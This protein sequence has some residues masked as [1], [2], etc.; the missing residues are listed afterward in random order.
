MNE[1]MSTDDYPKE[2]YRDVERKFLQD[3]KEECGEDGL[4]I[5]YLIV[6]NHLLP[7]IRQSAQLDC[8]S[9][10]DYEDRLRE[11]ESIVDDI[12]FALCAGWTERKRG[13]IWFNPTLNKINF[14]PDSWRD[15]SP[16]DKTAL[17]SATA[18]YL[19]CPWMQLNLLE[20]YILNGYIF[21]ETARLAD[22]IKSGEAIGYIN[23]A[24]LFSSGNLEKTIYWGT[25][26]RILKFLARWVLGPSIIVA[27]Y[28][29]GYQEVAKWAA[30]FYGIY[31]SVHI[32]FFPRR[33][34][35]RRTLRN[36][37]K[38]LEDKLHAL[39]N[40]YQS[41]SVEIFNPS[42]LREIIAR[43]ESEEVFFRPAVYSILDRAI[44]RDAAVFLLEGRH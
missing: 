8:L 29:A 4:P 30:I 39:V 40:V 17:D 37:L 22:S 34:L 33:F 5:Q 14:R 9:E 10:F 35:R 25:A 12:S 27:A 6:F 13:V 31:I 1:D 41:S 18:R 16:V 11:A 7:K 32:A 2:N 3:L 19:G 28:F 42:R 21:D 38:E 20:W 15:A 23:W 43:T 36:E 44:E 26:F 24:H